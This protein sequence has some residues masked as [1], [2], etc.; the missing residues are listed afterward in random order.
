MN[1]IC[2]K[3]QE[4]R[5]ISAGLQPRL[6]TGLKSLQRLREREIEPIVVGSITC[7]AV[8]VEDMTEQSTRVLQGREMDRNLFFSGGPELQLYENEI[9][10]LLRGVFVK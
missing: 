8:S 2:P 1:P 7:V 10:F 5:K 3:N 6:S 9:C 4:E